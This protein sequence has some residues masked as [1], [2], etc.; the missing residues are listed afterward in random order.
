[1]YNILKKKKKKE[2]IHN[3]HCEISEYFVYIIH[4]HLLLPNTCKNLI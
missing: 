1:M 3:L 4:F 2:K